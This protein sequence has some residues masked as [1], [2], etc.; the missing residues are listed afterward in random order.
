MDLVGPLGHGWAVPEGVVARAAVAG[1]L[2][3]A[4]LG[5]L[6]EELAERG[7]RGHASRRARRRAERLVAREL[8]ER[9]ARARRGRDRRRL[10]GRARLRDAARPSA[11]SPRSASTSSTP[12]VPSRCS[13]PSPRMLAEAGVACQVSLERLMA[14]GIGACLSCVVSHH[15]RAE[16]RVR[17]R[18]RLRCARRWSGMR[19]RYRRST[20]PPVASDVPHRLRARRCQQA[21]R[22]PRAR[23]GHGGGAREHRRRLSVRSAPG[24]AQP[25]DHRVRHVRVRAGVRRLHRPVAARRDRHQG[26]VLRALGR[27]RESAHRRDRERH[28]Q[29][30]RASEPGRRGVLSRRTSRG[31]PSTRPDTPVIVNVSGHSVDEYVA[32]HRAARSR[33]RPSRRTRSTSRVPTSMRAAWRSAPT[34]RRPPQRDRGVPGRHAAPAHREAQPQRHRH[35]GDRRSVEA[36]GAD[37]VSLI[38]TLLGM[39]IDAETRRPQARPRRRRAFRP[40]DQAGRAEDGVAGVAAR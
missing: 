25:G 13:A 24:A 40:G 20:R 7:R 12:A 30:D 15:R 37:A 21:G 26:R 9:V 27:Q 10:G 2:G 3:A 35:R 36:A 23:P 11:C 17:G 39:A 34:A 8:F 6:A 18:P 4:P 19:R 38:N 16:A 28:A 5:M 1:G 33:S 14:C 29:L 22:S 31:S 32:R